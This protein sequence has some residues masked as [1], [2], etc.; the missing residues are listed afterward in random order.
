LLLHIG[1]GCSLL[2]SDSLFFR[3]EIDRTTDTWSSSFDSIEERLVFLGEYLFMF[4]EVLDAEYHIVFYDN[5]GGMIPG[6]SDWDIR[7]ALH[8]ALE[9]IPLW[10]E[11]MQRLAPGQIDVGLWKELK[12]ERFT[13]QESELV[14]YWKRPN[15]KVVL[16]VF[17]E[18]GIVLKMAT[19]TRMIN[20]P[21]LIF[22]T[23]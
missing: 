22:E 23:G 12:S 17:P 14:E 3:E 18:S 5:S 16:V 19:T 20:W 15:S 4:S 1:V 8:I 2:T 9:D 10:T 13:W 7:V 11:G 6:P 21:E